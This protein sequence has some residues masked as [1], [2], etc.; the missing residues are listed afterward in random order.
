MSLL[1]LRY[2]FSFL[3]IFKLYYSDKCITKRFNVRKTFTEILSPDCS[4]ILLRNDSEAKDIAESRILSLLKRNIG[5]CF[6]FLL[7]KYN[8]LPLSSNKLG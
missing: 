7:S 5:S 3:I 8:F 6:K 4:G 2:F 1:R